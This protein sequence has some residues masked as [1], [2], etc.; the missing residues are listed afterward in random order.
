M[1]KM[2]RN[3]PLNKSAFAAA[4][5]IACSTA[6]AETISWYHFDEGEIG[7]KPAGATA[8]FVDSVTGVADGKAYAHTENQ[9][10]TEESAMP[11]FCEAFPN[12]AAWYDPVSKTVAKNDKWLRFLDPNGHWHLAFK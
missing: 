12:S 1:V 5:A 9:F 7:T 6:L 4:C 3:K 11:E 8:V 10:K 2:K